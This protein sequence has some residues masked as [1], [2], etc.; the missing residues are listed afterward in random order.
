MP[1]WHFCIFLAALLAFSVATSAPD[2]C[3]LAPL[4]GLFPLRKRPPYSLDYSPLHTTDRLIFDPAA[5]LSESRISDPFQL[6]TDTSSYGAASAS[7]LSP[8]DLAPRWIGSVPPPN[9]SALRWASEACFAHNMA[10]LTNLTDS[11]ASL[12]I[13]SSDAHSLFCFDYYV[14]ATS[15][16]FFLQMIPFSGAHTIH[17]SRWVCNHEREDVQANGFRIFLLPSG[18]STSLMDLFRLYQLVYGKDQ[19]LLCRDFL[20]RSLGME[21]GTRAGGTLTIDERDVQNGDVFGLLRMGGVGGMELYFSGS[22][23]SHVA[24]AIRNETGAL[25]VAETTDTSGSPIDIPRHTNPDC[26]ATISPPQ[27]LHTCHTTLLPAGV[28]R[29]PW[30]E[31][32]PMYG[33]RRYNIVWMRLAAEHRSRFNNTAA[34]QYFHRYVAPPNPMMIWGH[35]A[36]SVRCTMHS[37]KQ[38]GEGEGEKSRC[39]GRELN[40]G[41]HDGNVIFYH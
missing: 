33:G 23:V 8:L 20:K 16:R 15:H 27:T 11:G 24:V 12:V 19:E 18:L 37:H 30:A 40:P 9:G 41:H 39:V 1:L 7:V 36:G 10:L 34:W 31:W 21:F 35:E 32:L 17:I 28:R 25:F 29:T 38:E 5:G 2:S 22:V 14:I 26:H 3:P 4:G 13:Q 6:P